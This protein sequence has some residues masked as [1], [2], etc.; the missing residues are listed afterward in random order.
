MLNVHQRSLTYISSFIEDCI[1]FNDYFGS[2]SFFSSSKD[3]FFVALKKLIKK[4]KSGKE[5]VKA[6]RNNL[7]I[8]FNGVRVQRLRNMKL[9]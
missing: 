9:F 7:N 3:S 5:R 2:L 8:S 4:Q 1:N 6:S